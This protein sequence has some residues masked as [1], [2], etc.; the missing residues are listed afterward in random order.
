MDETIPPSKKALEEAL[1]LS[2]EILRNVE[3]GELE[4]SAIALK[5]SRLAR[6]L[7]DFDYQR[8]F[9]YEAS[10]YPSEPDGIQPEVWR[11]A[12]LGGRVFL[13]KETDKDKKE[14]LVERAYT[15]SIATLQSAVDLSKSAL[16]AA[17]DPNVSI[18]SANPHQIL[19]QPSGN[20]IERRGIRESVAAATRRLAERRAFVHQ[21]AST[22]HY[23]LK[24]SGIAD[25]IFS[26]RREQVD[27][28][29]GTIIPTAI[30]TLTAIYENLRSENPVDWSNAVHGCR[31]MLQDLADAISPPTDDRVIE[32][33]GRKQTIKMG[34]DSYINRLISFIE[35]NSKSDRFTSVVGSHL[36]YIGERLDSIFQA[37][38]KGSHSLIST[39]EEAD[40]YVVYTYL[41]IGDILSLQ[42][43]SAQNSHLKGQQAQQA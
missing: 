15:D 8:A 19:S 6:L 4:L 3:L 41:L 28:S 12:K 9:E 38:Q 30:Q 42:L 32:V 33:D 24:L 29:L 10:G 1:S 36:K 22:K 20:F 23:E 43:N 14:T 21:Y 25:D 34:A 13:D 35:C 26:R 27:G 40:R 11:I 18:S 39:Q 31:R 16:T 7:N 37:A 17:Q 5:T 2:D